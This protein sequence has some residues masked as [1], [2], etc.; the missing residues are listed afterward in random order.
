VISS[1][2]QNKSVTFTR[3]KY[4]T[5]SSDP[6]RKP[7]ANSI[8]LTI[9]SNPADIDQKLKA[10]TYDAKMN[11]DIGSA[12][13]TAVLTNAT[14]KKNADDAPTPF[15]R[16]FTVYQSTIP[17][18]HCRRAVFYATNKAAILQAYG[19][20]LH[21]TIAGSMTPITIPGHSETANMYP[22]GQKGTGDVA[23]AKQELQ[24]CGQP[25]GFSTKFAYSTPGET[26]PKVFQAMQAGLA[27]VGIKITAVTNNASSYYTSFVGSPRNIKAQNIG[28][29][30]YGWGADFP[31]GYGF[32][33]NIANGNAILQT[34][35]S[36]QP[37]LNDPVVNK[38]L[39]DSLTGKSTDADFRKLDDQVM[40]DAVYL[41]IFF[42]KTLWYRNP[43]L[44]NIT[45]DNA[46]GFG[47]YDVVNVGVSGS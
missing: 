4:W 1:Y 37:S 36:N 25:N 35:N 18:V 23:K 12:L 28:I 30:I 2:T 47:A 32:W 34:G 46:L 42:G 11:I 13:Q 26:G 3:N 38:V 17:N 16:F 7:L 27:R 14:L 31:T 5:K 29:S 43:R 10:G 45:C 8:T 33:Q 44:T 41:P 15:T 40:T 39:D 9:D 6:F 21:G 19:G 22:S 24:A 20:P